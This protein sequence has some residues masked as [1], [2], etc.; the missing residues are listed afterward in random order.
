MNRRAFP[1]VAA[2]AGLSLSVA[3]WAYY[4]EPKSPPPPD[5]AERQAMKAVDNLAIAAKLS[6]L[7][8]E[9]KSPLAL[10]A[11][12]EL[13]AKIPPPRPLEYQ[14]EESG[15]VLKAE[16]LKDTPAELVKEA[17]T[18]ISDDD[19]E[20]AAVAKK[21][22]GRVAERSRQGSQGPFSGIFPYRPHE[23]KVIMK[24]F[25]GWTTVDWDVAQ[26]DGYVSFQVTGPG[27]VQLYSNCG[28]NHHFQFFTPYSQVPARSGSRTS[29]ATSSPPRHPTTDGT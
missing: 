17:Q 6:R 9:S 29:Q 27:N 7:G 23:T 21:L 4:D 11:A 10:L 19:E 5:Q 18:L 2:L 3:A 15:P 28:P 16:V 12:A 22:S 14:T 20:L 24:K 1:C 13:M 25:E 26:G 8:R